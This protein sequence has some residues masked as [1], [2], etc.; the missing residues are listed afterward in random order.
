MEV[1]SLHLVPPRSRMGDMVL[2]YLKLRRARITLACFLASSLLLSAFPT[3]DIAISRVFFDNGFHLKEQW[4]LGSIREGLIY[5]LW[6]SMT[7]VVGL[8]VFNRLSKR[9]LCKIDGKKVCYLFLV[10]L[11]GAGLIV[12]V[13]FKDNFGRA[14]PR[15][16]EEFGGSKRFTPAF[17]VSYECNK[18]CSFSSGEAAGG[19]FSLALAMALS[20]RRAIFFTGIGLGSLVSL[21]RIASGAHFFSDTI[22][23]FFV[24]LIFTDVLHYYML[25]SWAERN[26]VPVELLSEAPA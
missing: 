9:N 22:V 3:I 1:L 24:M 16:V 10:L 17:V 13:I 25:S 11:L 19:F 4:W 12:N 6:L 2:N 20:R 23:S 8:Y 5:F 14:R 18:N 21:S 15:D 26:G 7:S